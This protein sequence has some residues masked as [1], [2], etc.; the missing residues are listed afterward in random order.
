MPKFIGIIPA[1]YASTRFPGKPLIDINGKSMIQR[2]YEQV[3]TAG[4]DNIYVAT[5]DDKIY[6]H[7]I[8]FGG[9]CLMTLNTHQSGTDR[10]N[11]CALKLQLNDDD[12]LVN[13]QGDEPFIQA[14]QITKL[15]KAFD[16]ENTKIATLI[17][18]IDSAEDLEKNTIPKVVTNTQHEAIYFSRSIIPFPAKK[19]AEELINNGIYFKHIGIYAYQIKTLK[20]IA[21]LQPS[22]LEQIESL[23]QLRWIENGYKIKTCITTEETIAIDTPDDL[24]KAIQFL[25]QQ[26]LI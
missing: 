19:T 3:L 2:V 22:L 7:V 14:S 8:S 11:E 12:V 6:E 17:K 15:C 4:L 25:N 20:N 9:N 23:E 13:I 5:D 24:E 26:R 16:D 21:K 1:R 18:R 10:C